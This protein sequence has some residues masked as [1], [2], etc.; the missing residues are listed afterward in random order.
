MLQRAGPGLP[1]L[2]RLF[3]ANREVHPSPPDPKNQGEVMR[4]PQKL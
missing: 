2:E 4:C 3:G 1:N